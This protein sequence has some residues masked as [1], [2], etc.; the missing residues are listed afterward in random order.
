MNDLFMVTAFIGLGAAI[1]A[2]WMNLKTGR[3]VF[4]I[5]AVV[6]CASVFLMSYPPNWRSG[7]VMSLFVGC[8]IVATAYVNTD[9]IAIRGRTYSLF[10]ESG[11]VNDYGSGLTAKKAWWMATLGVAMLVVI[12]ITYFANGSGAW[13]TAGAG[14]VIAL[15]AT[16]FGYRD[17]SMALPVAAGQRMQ[18]GLMSALTLG[19]FLLIY[20]GAFYAARR[21][22]VKHRTYRHDQRRPL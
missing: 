18:L 1:S 4:W 14:T 20:L 5:A 7:F 19:V 17:A 11:R 15:A 3:I 16:S 21:W 8:A 9:F 22:L 13:I 6:A 2:R 10:A 12:A